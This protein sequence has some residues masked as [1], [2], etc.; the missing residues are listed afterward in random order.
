MYDFLS[1]K[2][3]WLTVQLY[4]QISNAVNVNTDFGGMFV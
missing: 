4:L 2:Q 3:I 1:W